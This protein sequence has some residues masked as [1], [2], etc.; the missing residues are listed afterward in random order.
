M[1]IVWGPE[2]RDIEE[3]LLA[4]AD[5]PHPGQLSLSQQVSIFWREKD[6]NFQLED[7]VE[8]KSAWMVLACAEIKFAPRLSLSTNEVVLLRL[9]NNRRIKA[10]YKFCETAIAILT[11]SQ[12]PKSECTFLLNFRRSLYRRMFLPVFLTFD[13]IRTYSQT[14]MFWKKTI[15]FTLQLQTAWS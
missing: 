1:R 12:E 6:V 2:V 9:H 7:S 11:A 3:L 5:V 13:F 10:K 14:L 8:F 4:A 15:D